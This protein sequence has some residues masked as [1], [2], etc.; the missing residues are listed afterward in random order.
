MTCESELDP[1]QKDWNRKSN[2][3][4]L[5]DVSREASWKNEKVRRNTLERTLNV[6][7]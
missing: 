1:L 3:L 6:E 2:N 5:A 4:L 7:G